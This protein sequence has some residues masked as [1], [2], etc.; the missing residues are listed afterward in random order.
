ML[1]P[2]A[3]RL[4]DVHRR[5]Q[6][7]LRAAT[8]RDLLRLWPIFD[9]TRIRATWPGFREAAVLLVQVR[10][11]ISS[12]L[13][14]R[15]FRD[16]RNVLGIEGRTPTMHST[17][18]DAEIASGLESMRLNAVRQLALQRP[19]Q[20]IADAMFTNTAGVVSKF[21]LDHG[22]D[23][24]LSGVQGDQRAL[25]W[26]R[27][28]SGDPCPFCMMLA[29]RGAMYVSSATADFEAH[30][31]CACLPTPVYDSASWPGRDQSLAYRERYDRATAG[32]P[33]QDRLSAF[34]RAVESGAV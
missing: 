11:R 32:V 21:T 33:Y 13:A 26:A 30:R 6:L 3:K 1:P 2:P 29:S 5:A 15:F 17:P 24:L 12:G 28:T 22:R 16:Y 10:G 27:Q 31:S 14:A 9:I 7:A 34:R 20:Q 19:A 23:T 4:A 18:T 8:L 25:G